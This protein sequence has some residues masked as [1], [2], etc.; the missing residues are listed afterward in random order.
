M[1]G[2][3]YATDND[4]DALECTICGEYIDNNEQYHGVG[5]EPCCID[6]GVTIDDLEIGIE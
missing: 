5:F 1:R 2:D 4:V 6:C 3:V